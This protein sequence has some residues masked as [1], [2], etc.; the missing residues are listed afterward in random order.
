MK[1]FLPL[2]NLL[3]F[4]NMAH[5]KFFHLMAGMFASLVVYM[6][7]FSLPLAFAAAVV[8]GVAKEIFDAFGNGTVDFMDAVATIAGGALLTLF[9]AAL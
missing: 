7:G 5:D 4:H 2:Y 1:F 9:V 3:N 6:L 8:A